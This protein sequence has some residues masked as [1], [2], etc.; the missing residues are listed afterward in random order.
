MCVCPWPRPAGGTAA[1][2]G[3]LLIAHK[4][5]LFQFYCRE[6]GTLETG[7]Q[8]V[9]CVSN[10]WMR[11]GSQSTL[12][13][14]TVSSYATNGDLGLFERCFL[15]MLK[16]VCLR[17]RSFL[18]TSERTLLIRIAE[19]VPRHPNRTGKGK[20][21]ARS[22]SGAGPSSSSSGKQQTGGKKSSGKKKK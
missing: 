20:A 16:Y 13:S 1:T 2:V 17:N 15:Y 18:S 3:A 19:L 22:G 9:V 21:E 4:H 12:R 5:I 11:M 7:L 10:C 6:N 8:Q 14:Q